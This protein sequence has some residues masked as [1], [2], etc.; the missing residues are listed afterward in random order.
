[1]GAKYSEKGGGPAV[2]LGQD[3]VQWLS[4]GLN[5]GS[6][7]TGNPAGTDAY[8]R[9]MGLSGVL[10][11]ILSGGAG[12]LGGSLGALLQQQQTNDI[13][14][15]RGR[16]NVGGGTAYGTPGMNAEVAYRAQ[17]APQIATQVG[18]LQMGALMPLLGMLGETASR[19]ITQ[20]QGVMQPSAFGSAM[21]MLLPAAG[22]I[23][24]GP[25]GDRLGGWLGGLGGGGAAQTAMN[26][27][28][29]TP[30]FV[31]IQGQIPLMPMGF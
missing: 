28:S 15:L 31:P 11:D 5:T 13:G 22:T 29:M 8:G 1:M 9:T 21:G 17:A 12:N 7:G 25:L 10:N 16:F 19:G 6:F 30:N 18:Q 3:W 24:G 2:G 27:F 23:L 20:R 26:S 4:Q 14:A